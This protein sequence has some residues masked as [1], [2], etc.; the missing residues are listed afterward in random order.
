MELMLHNLII[1]QIL[2]VIIHT[3]CG[4]GVMLKGTIIEPALS[5]HHDMSI[6][7]ILHKFYHSMYQLEH[8]SHAQA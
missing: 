7:P 3:D 8:G 5:H 4:A 2:M 6:S 1:V